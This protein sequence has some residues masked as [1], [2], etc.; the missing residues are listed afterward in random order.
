M[1]TTALKLAVRPGQRRRVTQ[2]DLCGARGDPRGQPPARQIDL[3]ARQVHAGH[4]THVT[5][6]LCEEHP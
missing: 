2:D 5:C 3:D 6:L 4:V 1:H